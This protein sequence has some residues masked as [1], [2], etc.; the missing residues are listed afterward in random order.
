[1]L[2]R[3][4]IL[5]IPQYNTRNRSFG[6]GF[7]VFRGI[8]SP[9][10]KSESS[11]HSLCGIYGDQRFEGRDADRRCGGGGAC[12]SHTPGVLP[13]QISFLTGSPSFSPT[14]GEIKTGQRGFRK[15]KGTPASGS[16]QLLKLPSAHSFASGAGVWGRCPLRIWSSGG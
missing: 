15:T 2:F 16:G 1:M 5:H 13:D 10:S 14:K 8:G 3:V 9:P 7:Y 4:N 11:S 12:P 6:G